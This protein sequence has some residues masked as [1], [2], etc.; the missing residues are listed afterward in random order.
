MSESY[1]LHAMSWEYFQGDLCNL[2]VTLIICIIVK[3]LYLETILTR[4]D[5]E[6]QNISSK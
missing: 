4:N 2:K 1:R 5:N 6:K 3:R